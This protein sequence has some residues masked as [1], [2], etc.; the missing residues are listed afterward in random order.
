MRFAPPLALVL[1][2]LSLSLAHAEPPAS[3]PAG[4]GLR[5]DLVW[6]RGEHSKDSGSRTT[7]YHVGDG[8]LTF[9]VRAGGGWRAHVKPV[10][11]TVAL[12]AEDL[13]K[14]SETVT[15]HHLAHDG[16]AAH[17]VAGSSYESIALRV[18]T[19]GTSSKIE[20]KGGDGLDK[21]DPTY[22]GLLDLVE[23]LDAALAAGRKRAAPTGA[24]TACT[25]D[26]DC[27]LVNGVPPTCCST[28]GPHVYARAE[29]EKLRATCAEVWKQSGDDRRCPLLD[30]P[31]IHSSAVC[32]AGS[33]Q[34][35]ESPC[36]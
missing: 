33:C 27:E 6:V 10:H 31:C 1:C 11:E 23:T 34:L 7:T 8:T 25:T 20:V 19:N 4:A 24:G 15:R 28:C 36:K 14:I 12:T 2:A 32:R 26:D 30:C 9:D 18:T 17:D 5:L 35:Q 13:T 21:A 22:P 3:R 16:A 29:A